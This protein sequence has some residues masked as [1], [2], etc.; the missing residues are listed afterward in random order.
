MRPLAV[1]ALALLLTGCHAGVPR[2]S[3]SLI[4]EAP[5]VV[6]VQYAPRDEAEPFWTFRLDPGDAGKAFGGIGEDY[7]GGW[8]RTVDAACNTLSELRLTDVV[9]AHQIGVGGTLSAMRE[10]PEE[11]RGLSLDAADDPCRPG[12]STGAP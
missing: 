4:S 3:Y 1:V 9:Q 8:V 5:Q 6:W 10:L 7:V 11:L 2:H 12:L